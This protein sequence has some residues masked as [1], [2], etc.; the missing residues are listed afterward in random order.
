MTALTKAPP[1]TAA[2]ARKWVVGTVYQC[3]RSASPGYHIGGL[4][5]CYRSKE[6]WIVLRGDDGFED[7][8][9]MLV[10]GFVEDDGK[11]ERLASVK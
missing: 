10:S 1:L 4:Y 2:Q 3:I 9:H 11:G 7:V 8:T 6:G 5:P